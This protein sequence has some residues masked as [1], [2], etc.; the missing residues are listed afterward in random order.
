MK[1]TSEIRYIFIFSVTLFPE[2][3]ISCFDAQQKGISIL[4][5]Y[6]RMACNNVYLSLCYC[7]VSRQHVSMVMGVLRTTIVLITRRTTKETLTHPLHTKLME[8]RNHILAGG[9]NFR[10]VTLR[11]LEIMPGYTSYGLLGEH[12]KYESCIMVS[13]EWLQ[14]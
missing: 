13:L 14:L 8:L 7:F 5:L 11:E 4:L 12:G 3:L 2:L 6:P 10:F 1:Q 9:S